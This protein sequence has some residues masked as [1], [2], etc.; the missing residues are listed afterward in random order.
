MIQA[1]GA[2]GGPRAS[3]AL[4]ILTARPPATMHSGENLNVRDLKRHVPSARGARED[5][6]GD[7]WAARRYILI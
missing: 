3:G 2:A 5:A 1:V 7:G 6:L 4:L